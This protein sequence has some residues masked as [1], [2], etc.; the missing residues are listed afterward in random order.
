MVYFVGNTSIFECCKKATIED[1]VAFCS[2]QDVLGVDTETEGLNFIDDKVIMFQIGNKTRQYVIDTR[3]INIE[4]LRDV[5]ESKSILKIFHNVKFDY[6]FIKQH[7]KITCENIWDT[8]LAERV[9]HNGMD[10]ISYKLSHMTEKYTK[11]KLDKSVRD[12]F[13]GRDGAPFTQSEIIYGANDVKHLGTIREKQMEH[14]TYEELSLVIQLENDSSLALADIEF[15]GLY[16]NKTEWLKLEAINIK[17]AEELKDSLDVIVENDPRFESLKSKYIQGDLF[18]DIADMKK[19]HVKWTS[20][21]QVLNVF[22]TLIP[23]LEDV[24]GNNLS[25]YQYRRNMNIITVY[26]RYKEVMKLATSYGNKFL[27]NIWSDGK[28]HTNF[29]QLLDT[30]RVSSSRPNMQQIPADNAYRNCFTTTNNR[31]FVSADYSSQELNVIAY[32]SQDPVWLLALSKG[33]DLHST[34]ASLVY[35]E[36]WKNSAE[37]GCTF[38]VSRQKCECKEHKRLRTNVK[39][40]NFGLAYGMGP[41]K[42]A[43]T[44]NIRKVDAS[45]LIHKYFNTFPSIRGFL[46]LLGDYGKERG[47]IKTFKPYRRIRYFS[48]WKANGYIDKK[49]MGTIERASKNTPI[50]GCSADM[51]KLALIKIRDYINLKKIPVKIVM[52]VHDQIDTTVSPGYAD[53]WVTEIKELMEEAAKHIITN[54]LLGAEVTVTDCWEK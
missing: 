38:N 10:N 28:I 13:V 50:Q 37:E 19:I 47:Y 21:K 17:K 5:L 40:V 44:L 23:E 20:P 42:L 8:M 22:K 35:G 32:G 33:E 49:Y 15:N 9:I 30:G 24:N 18:V 51:T 31:K 43:D 4:P 25:K 53:T 52:T 54:G 14:S 27:D 46:N 41:N 11:K 34:C 36:E 2:G 7:Y 6:K 26:R 39:T 29:F 3:Y 12:G 48:G 1:V 16:I 45:Q